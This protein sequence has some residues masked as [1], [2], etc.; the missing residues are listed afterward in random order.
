MGISTAVDQTR[1]RHK[2]RLAP[3]Q[4]NGSRGGDATAAGALTHALTGALPELGHSRRDVVVEGLKVADVGEHA[5]ARRRSRSVSPLQQTLLGLPSLGS[6]IL[7]NALHPSRAASLTPCR[8]HTPLAHQ[9][10]PQPGSRLVTV[11]AR[12]AVA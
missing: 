5:A 2:R 4:R 1:Q 3:R 9:L 6:G 10:L 12:V 11:S 8:L 7:A